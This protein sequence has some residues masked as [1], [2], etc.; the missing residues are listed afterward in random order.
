MRRLR[1]AFAAATGLKSLNLAANHNSP[2]RSTKSTPSHMRSEMWEVRGGNKDVGCRL[3][4][5]RQRTAKLTAHFQPL[6]SH[7]FNSLPTSHLSPLNSALTACKLMVS[8]TIS[9]PSRG[10]FHLSLTV[11][12]AIGCQEVFSLGRWSSRL[13]TEFLVFRATWVP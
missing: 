6:T 11:L 13:H 12:S 2:A 8:G 9:L 10:A 5:M 4:A 1:L 3:L 7:Y